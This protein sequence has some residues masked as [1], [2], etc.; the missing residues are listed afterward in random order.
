MQGWV[1]RTAEALDSQFYNA[2]IGSTTTHDFGG[3]TS[4]L[5]TSAPYASTWSGEARASHDVVN[6][7]TAP[8]MVVMLYGR[9]DVGQAWFENGSGLA[10][11]TA[12]VFQTAFQNTV[13]TINTGLPKTPLYIMGIIPAS[14]AVYNGGYGESNRQDFNAGIQSALA[15]LANANNHYISMDLLGYGGPPG[16]ETATDFSLTTLDGLHPN[17]NGRDL[18]YNR[19]YNGITGTPTIGIVPVVAYP[20][21][22]YTLRLSGF[23]TSWTSSCHLTASAG[24]LGSPTV[25][26]DGYCTVSYTAPAAAQT[27][28]ITDTVSGAIGHLNVVVPTLTISPTTATAG[29]SVTLMLTAPFTNWVPVSQASLFTA[30]GLDLTTATVTGLGTASATFIAPASSVVIKDTSTGQTATLE[31]GTPT[32]TPTPTPTTPTATTTTTSRS[33]MKWCPRLSRR[34]R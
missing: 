24:T 9:N 14:A 7:P 29:Q 4:A 22:S 20:S 33:S 1:I 21:T 30:P 5:G 34:G 12:S 17:R 25:D 15:T 23:G 2:G 27:V 26:L 13:S 6:S 3:A 11:E 8:S 10:L 31:I 16:S 28:V 32:P 18:V 19:L